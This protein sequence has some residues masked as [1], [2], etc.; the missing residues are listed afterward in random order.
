MYPTKVVVFGI[1]VFK[2]S[3]IIGSARFE[4]VVFVAAGLQVKNQIKGGPIVDQPTE[5]GEPVTL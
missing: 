5:Q 1:V 3:M 4:N 2:T